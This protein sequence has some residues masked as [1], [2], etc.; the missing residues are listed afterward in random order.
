MWQATPGSTHRLRRGIMLSIG[1]NR[2]QSSPRKTAQFSLSPFPPT[3]AHCAELPACLEE[4]NHQQ[5]PLVHWR[6]RDARRARNAM[7]GMGSRLITNINIQRPRRLTTIRDHNI[8]YLGGFKGVDYRH[9]RFRRVH[10][11]MFYVFI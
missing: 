4:S 1:P 2:I 10:N 5:A 8:T 11:G 7:S 3:W 6:N 9:E